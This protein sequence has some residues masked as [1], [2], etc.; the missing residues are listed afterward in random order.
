[1]NDKV[2]FWNVKSALKGKAEVA[3]WCQIIEE[4]VQ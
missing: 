4:L 3:D 1:M 2:E